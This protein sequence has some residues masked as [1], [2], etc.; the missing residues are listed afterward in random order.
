M[1]PC[2]CPFCAAQV[3]SQVQ[4]MPGLVRLVDTYLEDYN[5]T[6]TSPMKLVLFLDAIEHVSR[7]CRIIRQPL[8]NALLLGV[9]GSGRQSLARLAA[10]M[11]DYEVV[12]IEIAKGYGNNEWREV[13]ARGMAGSAIPCSNTTAD[14]SQHEE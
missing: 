14:I 1:S 9:G 3:Y 13:R 11:C 10:F 5:S 12:Q 6:S 2:Y 8:G 7:I 4:D